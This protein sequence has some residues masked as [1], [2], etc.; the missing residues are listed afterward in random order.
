MPH[1]TP[2][3]TSARGRGRRP[4]LLAGVVVAA[5]TAGGLVV[6]VSPGSAAPDDVLT[7]SQADD[8]TCVEKPLTDSPSTDTR[9]VTSTVDGVVQARLSGGGDWDLAVFD[10]RT[11]TVV[12]GSAGYRANELAEGFVTQGQSLVVQGCRYAGTSAKA[13]LSIEFFAAVTPAMNRSASAVD[14]A[15]LVRVSTKTRADKRRLQRLGLDITEHGSRS[16]MEVV[17]HN[18]VDV[19]TLRRAGFSY[20]VQ[21]ADLDAR[22]R[23]NRAAD[24]TYAAA[25][26]RSALPSGRTSYRRLYDYQLEMKRLAARYPTLVRPLTLKERTIEGRDVEG[27]EITQDAANLAD[28]KP[29]FFNMGV[30]HARE[31]PSAELPMEF[32]YDLI[33]RY[34]TDSGVRKLMRGTRTIIVPIVNPDGFNV[35][36][37]APSI[38]GDF[39]LFDYEYKRKNCRASDS[40]A[41]YRGGTCGANAAGRLRGTD[42]NR[43]YGGFWGGPGAS[44]SWSS[45]TYRGSAP[46]SEPE[47]RNVRA[48]V[49]SRQVTTL[50]SNHTYSN[51]IL[52]APGVFDTRPPLD[53]PVS[54]K[55]ADSMAAH[56]QYTSVPGYELYDTS[57]TTDDWSFWITGGFGYTFEIGP[58]EFH[59]PY[60]TGVVAEYAGLAPAAGAGKGGNRVAY[61]TALRATANPKLHA[62]IQGTAPAGATLQVRKR[63]STP[64]SPVI[65]PDGSVGD[66][67]QV[68][69]TLTSSY[70]ATGGRFQFAVNPSTRPYV[71]GR[72]GR[73]PLAPPQESITLDN[74]TGIPAENQDADPTNVGDAERIPFIVEGLPDVDNAAAKVTISWG[75]KNVDWDLYVVDAAGQVV[76]SSASGGTDTETAVLRDPPAGEYTA[77]VVNYEGGTTSDWS[78]GEVRFENPIPTTY[79]PKETW[80]LRCTGKDGTVLGAR[81]VFVDRGQ[82]VDVG[83]VCRASAAKAGPAK[84]VAGR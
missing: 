67:L 66:P 49:S 70:L 39:S 68:T 77:V 21:I 16:A 32:A 20:R 25:T 63:F 30:H 55:L 7:A 51:L 35:S 74:P 37:E 44:T 29:V 38:G 71:A 80:R 26:S 3:V 40:P 6:G 52:R 18:E 72:L 84:A 60:A 61:Y 83:S 45:D 54:K 34:R 59:P 58:E 28:G 64:T 65:Q 36:R 12:A 10:G 42:P 11:G 27:I 14:K 41:E 79:G 1:P 23:A 53:E 46:F 48:L 73:D 57:G 22:S 9:T 2:S 24:R 62:T 47:T 4:A 82:V 5:V 17:L 75:D 19:R 56:N 33:N 31:W 15:Q 69:D 50:I 81:D 76:G 78:G 8:L 13:T 43:N